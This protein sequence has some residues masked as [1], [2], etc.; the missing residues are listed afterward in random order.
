MTSDARPLVT[1]VIPVY[2]HARYV[3]QAIE[4]VLAQTYPNIEV[5]VIDDGSKDESPKVL[6]KYAGRGRF[7]VIINEKNSGQSAV[8]NQALSLAKGEFVC[9]LPSDDW[10]LPRKIELQVAKFAEC[11]PDVGVV[12]GRG[13]RYF[14]DYG[15][16]HP[17]DLPMLRGDVLG[18]LLERG[19]FICPVTP[20]M[21]AECFARVRP[22]ESYTAEGEAIYQRL[23]LYWRFDY[24]DETVA[25]MRD[26]PGN[27]GKRIYML[28]G[29]M[30]RY[31][32]MIFAHPDL[33]AWALPLKPR[34]VANIHLAK[35]VQFMGEAK[36][37]KTGRQV[38][39]KAL[40]LQ[41]RFALR[42]RV[43][44]WLTVSMLPKPVAG[45]LVDRYVRLPHQRAPGKGRLVS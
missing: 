37:F 3:D 11:G 36:D 4:S 26:H 6:E 34:R 41:P 16:T 20:M 17:M 7:T 32:D 24:V 30:L 12:Y 45:W 2:N 29:E 1:V 44:A 28:Y 27:T 31:V 23:A 5:I 42:P 40:R 14:E 13:E 22:D 9:M 33:P 39:W 35:G 38:L 18:F 19:N 25:V 8:Y 15:L 21:R 43:L 10:F